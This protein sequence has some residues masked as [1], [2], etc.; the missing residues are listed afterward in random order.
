MSRRLV[1]KLRRTTFGLAVGARRSVFGEWNAR[2]DPSP[3]PD[4]RFDLELTTDC[5]QTLAHANKSE[6]RL[7][8][9]VAGIESSSIIDYFDMQ[10][11]VL[12]TDYCGSA[13]RTAMFCNVLNSLLNDA[14]N[15]KRNFPREIFRKFAA[16]KIYRQP[17]GFGSFSAEAAQRHGEAELFEFRWVEFVRDSMYIR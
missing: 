15:T 5:D 9:S 10:D 7:H 11:T 8:M 12:N 16:L 1:V 4:L 3:C 13:G 14:K 17:A 6:R 2:D